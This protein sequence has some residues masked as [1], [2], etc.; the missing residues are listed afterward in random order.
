MKQFDH[1]CMILQQ[2]YK[3]YGWLISEDYFA[4]NKPS[5]EMMALAV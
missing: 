4:I 2:D 3:P 5:N 1:Y